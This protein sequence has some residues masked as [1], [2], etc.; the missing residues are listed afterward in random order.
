MHECG[1]RNMD[2]NAKNFRYTTMGFGDFAKEVSNGARLYLRALSA[3][4]PAD[5]PANLDHDFPELA[6]DFTLPE[7]LD[8]CRENMH[9]SV[10]R[11]SGQVSSHHSRCFFRPCPITDLAC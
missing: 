9:S 11:V 10:L 6:A 5:Q 4:A 3:N 8:M 2:F 7:A 1:V